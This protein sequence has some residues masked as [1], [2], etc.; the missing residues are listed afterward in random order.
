M[1]TLDKQFSSLEVKNYENIKLDVYTKF[2]LKPVNN[3]Y[4]ILNK[5]NKNKHLKGNYVECGTFKGTTLLSA[6]QFCK[7]NN[8]NTKLVGIDTFGGFP[9]KGLHNPLDLPDHFIQL[10]KSQKITQDH[11]EKAKIRTNNFTSLTHLK[12]EY[13]LDTEQVF[14]NCSKFENI[15]LV[16]GTFEEITPTY[17]EP[18]AVLHLDGD[19][20]DSYLTCLNNLYDNVLPGGCIIFDEYYSHKYPGAR[21]AVDKF[22]L[23]KEN[24]GCF[25]KYITSEGHERWCFKKIFK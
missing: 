22:F 17:N 2:N 14:S 13:F 23:E 6:A 5:I 10:F 18:I 25:E 4:L 16:K 11:F 24:E 12:S 15:E 21:V 20:Y 1:K 3:I 9:Y 8:I 19:L 7:Q